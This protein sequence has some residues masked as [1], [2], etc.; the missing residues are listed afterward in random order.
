MGKC[1]TSSRD[2]QHVSTASVTWSFPMFSGLL[3]PTSIVFLTM[4]T[5]TSGVI[6][7]SDTEG[8]CSHKISNSVSYQTT[9]TF[10]E[11]V[12][13]TKGCGFWDW[14]RCTIYREVEKTRL[15]IRYRRAY[16]TAMRC[17]EGWVESEASTTQ[18]RECIR[19]I[20]PTT[21]VAPGNTSEISEK[22]P[23]PELPVNFSLITT[24][25]ATN[26]EVDTT[27]TGT[28]PGGP[29]S[30][31]GKGGGLFTGEN[32]IRNMMGLI[33]II[34]GVLI[35]IIVIS[36]IAVCYRRKRRK[37]ERKLSDPATAYE[38][39]TRG[40]AS[41][42]RPGDSAY[43]EIPDGQTPTD[44]LNTSTSAASDAVVSDGADENHETPQQPCVRGGNQYHEIADLLHQAGGS[45]EFPSPSGTD[46]YLPDESLGG[47]AYAYIDS[48]GLNR[49]GGNGAMGSEGNVELK[50]GAT[51]KYAEVHKV[52]QV[53][54]K[55]P[56]T[57]VDD[58]EG[59]NVST[60]EHEFIPTEIQAYITHVPTNADEEDTPF[61]RSDLE[62]KN[63]KGNDNPEPYDEITIGTSMSPKPYDEVQFSAR[64]DPEPYDEVKIGL[65]PQSIEYD[66]F[67]RTDGKS[68]YTENGNDGPQPYGDLDPHPYGETGPTP[69]LP[70]S[71]EY[72]QFKRSNSRQDTREIEPSGYGVVLGDVQD[73]NTKRGSNQYATL[74]G[75]HSNEAARSPPKQ[76]REYDRLDR[77][78]STT[79]TQHGSPTKSRR[80]EISPNY[81]KLN[82]SIS[83]Q[84]GEELRRL[85]ME[86]LATMDMGFP[87]KFTINSIMEVNCRLLFQCKICMT[88]R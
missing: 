15:E 11:T 49:D 5:L 23:T 53:H 2:S 63:S 10:T 62:N 22:L 59:V 67:Q 55:S 47:Y 51:A 50:G 16:K 31:P 4:S 82:R 68:G 21:T 54:P 84:D 24:V 42:G 61:Q 74:D 66:N 81:S 26:S 48:K 33:G 73:S 70:D 78:I 52:K 7:L 36:V 8:Y 64:M 69:S 13:T 37:R 30:N 35:V 34:A 29:V 79:S 86:P 76:S 57:G 25:D 9:V 43:A 32:K 80:Q 83:R 20:Q 88:L 14:D 56:G 45:V 3:L 60:S 77:Q 58:I 18:L 12:R 44:H 27:D 17:C 85:A 6:A 71:T 65:I 41:N 19:I 38:L 1:K 87:Q 39:L 28:L 75:Q 72:D 46:S 40:G